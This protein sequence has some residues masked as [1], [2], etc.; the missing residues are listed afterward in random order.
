MDL[1]ITLG[2]TQLLVELDA[3]LTIPFCA[4]F[5]SVQKTKKKKRKKK[6]RLCSYCK[7]VEILYHDIDIS[8]RT[9]FGIFWL[10]I[11]IDICMMN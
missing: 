6:K 7:Q 5:I 4:N 8:S 11:D 1:Q 2:I 3:K 10:D 9:F